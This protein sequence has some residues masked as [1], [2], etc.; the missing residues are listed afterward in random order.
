MEEYKGNPVEIID[1][2]GDKKWIDFEHIA[3]NKTKFAC[4]LYKYR[5][6]WYFNKRNGVGRL[7]INK[8]NIKQILI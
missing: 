5:G 8:E 3:N 4:L 1:R 2:F 6:K 7:L